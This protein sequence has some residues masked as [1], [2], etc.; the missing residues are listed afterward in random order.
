MSKVSTLTK[1]KME[2]LVTLRNNKVHVSSIMLVHIIQKITNQTG[3]AYLGE[4][5]AYYQEIT[6]KTSHKITYSTGG[7]RTHLRVLKER[8]YIKIT[9]DG[10]YNKYSTTMKGMLSVRGLF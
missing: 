4:I 9:K 8:G 1:T 5:E 10:M 2:Q 3:S 7:I 6:S